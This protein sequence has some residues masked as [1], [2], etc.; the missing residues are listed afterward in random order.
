MKYYLS[1]YKLGNEIEK[2]KSLIAETSGKFGYIPNALDFTS[3]DPERRAAH[4]E[5]DLNDLRTVGSE[6][7]ELNLK[8][9][10]GKSDELKAKLEDL[11][12]VYIS[13]G[14]SFVLRQSMKL[15]GF[16]SLLLEMQD[17]AD[18]LY[19]GYSAAVCVLTPDLH[20]YAI[21]DDATD[22]PY[23]Q[24]KE[25]IWEGLGILD[26]IFEPHYKS[27]HHESE[28]TDREI[29][30]CVENKILFKAYRDGEVLI[31]E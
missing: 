26:F 21:T 28:S 18:F 15:S 16:D 17:R 31:L 29:E 25:Q 30:Y 24:L 27:D 2:L 13:G 7:E 5:K 6:V 9:Y 10:F 23:P 8:D 4:I 1:S 11:G 22:F 14:N 19:M 3:A 12:G 20:A